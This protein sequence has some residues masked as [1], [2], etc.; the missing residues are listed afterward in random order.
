MDKLIS[1]ADGAT[2]QCGKMFDFSLK[3]PEKSEKVLI[4]YFFGN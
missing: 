1:V 2:V 3:V 4:I